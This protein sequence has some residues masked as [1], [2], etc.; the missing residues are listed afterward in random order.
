MGWLTVPSCAVRN[1][2]VTVV[3]GLANN[4]AA[5][6]LYTELAYRN[7]MLP[8][9]GKA[10]TRLWRSNRHFSSDVML[11]K[12]VP[13]IQRTNLSNTVLLLKAKTAMS[14]NHSRLKTF[15][16]VYGSRCRKWTS[17]RWS[18]WCFWS[19]H[20]HP[21]HVELWLHGLSVPLLNG[22]P[23]NGEL[24]ILVMDMYPTSN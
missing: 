18:A 12:A 10:Q 5:Q 2:V 6:G 24:V 17:Q 7:E 22:S 11:A 8:T 19:G 3:L 9:V 1:M 15:F 4:F 14:Q 23:S 21:R 13:E 16:A 20:G